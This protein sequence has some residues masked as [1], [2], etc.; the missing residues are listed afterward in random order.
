MPNFFPTVHIVGQ[1][2]CCG[3]YEVV[4][5]CQQ[6]GLPM[7]CQK[8]PCGKDGTVFCCFS[9]KGCW[10][11][12]KMMLKD[13]SICCPGHWLQSKKHEGLP[14]HMVEGSWKE[15]SLYTKDHQKTKI[16]IIAS[17]SVLLT[18]SIHSSKEDTPINV[19]CIS[20]G[21]DVVAS[22]KVPRN[23]LCNTTL[24][25]VRQAVSE[26]ISQHPC[27]IVLLSTDSTCLMD[28]LHLEQVLGMLT[29]SS[30]CAQQAEEAHAAK[31]QSA[32]EEALPAD[33]VSPALKH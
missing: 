3:P 19:S 26:Q 23:A 1:R 30:S 9:W 8:G 13:F 33:D 31:E 22:M 15:R 32:V 17:G 4:P 21:G 16:E 28:E 6:E 18:L 24:S 20:M 11:I 14:P 10:R 25:M 27:A 12:D 29:D 5:A 2:D 7:W